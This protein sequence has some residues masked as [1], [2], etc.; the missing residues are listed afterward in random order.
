MSK[1]INPEAAARRESDREADGQFGSRTFT[2]PDLALGARDEAEE[3]IAR[4]KEQGAML[5][6]RWT[7]LIKRTETPEGKA[8]AMSY[9]QAALDGA[10]PLS[11]PDFNPGDLDRLGQLG[12]TR[13][14]LVPAERIFGT[15]LAGIAEAG[16]G[17]DRLALLVE[18]GKPATAWSQWER[19]AL[20][21]APDRYL[22]AAAR[23]PEHYTTGRYRYL[24]LSLGPRKNERLEYARSSG[25]TDPVLVESRHPVRLLADLQAALPDEPPRS[26]AFLADMG[27]TAATI[28][29]YGMQLA[30]RFPAADLERLGMT[31]EAASRL[32]NG[33]EMADAGQ[34]QD[35]YNRGYRNGSQTEGIDW[36]DR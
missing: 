13:T 24:V 14:T 30:A 4:M 3:L 10:E 29:R 25:I 19:E 5:A 11:A 6:G 20:L 15:G 12:H 36:N 7:S 8:L 18:F 1:D 26:V 28:G 31:P 35:A 33:S 27:H 23:L 17:P 2:A 16:V 9:L 22:Q 32:F 34:L 21:G